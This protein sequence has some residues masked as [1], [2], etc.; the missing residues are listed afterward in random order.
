LVVSLFTSLLALPLELAWW[1]VEWDLWRVLP[2]VE[3]TGPILA[4]TFV[5]VWWANSVGLGWRLQQRLPASVHLRRSRWLLICL[6]V[7][8]PLVGF[9]FFVLAHRRLAARSR[10]GHPRVAAKL[11]SRPGWIGV[12]TTRLVSWWGAVRIAGGWILPWYFASIGVFGWAVLWLAGQHGPGV[13]MALL[14]AAG[15]LHI[16]AFGVRW[17][18]GPEAAPFSAREPWEVRFHQ[19]ATWLLLLPHPVPLLWLMMSLSE[20]KA[21]KLRSQGV[22]RAAFRTGTQVDRLP[23]WRGLSRTLHSRWE[24][25]SWKRRWFHPAA[26]TG[27]KHTTLSVR[28]LGRLYRFKTALIFF[29]GV[30]LGWL[31]SVLVARRLAAPGLLQDALETLLWGGLGMA[32]LGSLTLLGC[33]VAVLLKLPV[34]FHAFGLPLLSK[35][36]ALT[37][38]AVI[39]GCS[40]GYHL[41]EGDLQS[42]GVWLALPVALFLSFVAFGVILRPACQGLPGA[43]RCLDPAARLVWILAPM[44]LAVAGVVLAAGGPMAR[45]MSTLLFLCAGLAPLAHAALAF[46]LGG[47]LLRPF[48]LGDLTSRSLPSRR[49]RI[50]RLLTATLVLPLGGLVIPWWIFLQSRWTS[51]SA[52]CRR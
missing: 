13:G 37:C 34:R 18:S 38:G 11:D 4:V 6:L 2:L 52:R 8:L 14:V 29:D 9:H 50:P 33:W 36:L 10:E 21:E 45:A 5:G 39:L 19:A 26:E 51:A 42:A 12:A 43:E 28:R 47:W 46:I 16:V 49:R 27:S 17:S 41:G 7:G 3:D 20:S 24:G 23:R 22:V 25:V 31:L 35:F 15:G 1:G 32:L 44:T 30:L 48:T 40:T